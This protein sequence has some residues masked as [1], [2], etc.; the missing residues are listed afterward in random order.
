M[1]ERFAV[2]ALIS[3]AGCGWANPPAY[4][5]NA[6]AGHSGRPDASQKYL[7]L[8]LNTGTGPT[9]VVYPLDG[10]KPLRK[11]VDSWRVSDLA[12][13]PWGDVYTSDDNPSGGEVTAY[14]SGGRSALFSMYAGGVSCMT[15]DARGYLYACEDEYVEEFAPRSS[16]R[17]RV[18]RDAQNVWAIALDRA[19]NVYAA[20]L[21]GAGS[22]SNGAVK[23][24]RPR[25]QRPFR[26]LRHGINS[27]TA[28][29]FDSHG[30]L[31]VANSPGYW[32]EKGTGSVSEYAP[33]SDRPLRV[34][35]DGINTPT[36]LAIGPRDELFVANNVSYTTDANPDATIK[37]RAWISV[38]GPMGHSPKHRI[39]G[40]AQVPQIT[41]DARGNLYAIAVT[42]D[43]A[44]IAV[45]NQRLARVRTITDGVK[46]A[47]AIAIGP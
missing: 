23:V 3:L 18:A 21:T 15:F 30:N 8:G 4:L 19:G 24:F 12:V 31:Y 34:L 38:Y 13:D 5:Q 32:Q 6:S 33:G 27:P 40:F 7:Y 35:R 47:Q 39:N 25:E 45:F 1:F 44:E 9:L 17:I 10:S 28:L 37:S 20:Q 41:L 29:A 36:S 43:K 22:E 26:V 16:K 11:I 42:N 46:G 14:T 2:I